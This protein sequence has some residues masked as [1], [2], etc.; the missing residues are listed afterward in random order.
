MRNPLQL[1]FFTIKFKVHEQVAN[2]DKNTWLLIMGDVGVVFSLASRATVAATCR[3]M[4][5]VI[6][7]MAIC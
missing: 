4:D 1:P 7:C 6:I 5:M 2:T 3:C